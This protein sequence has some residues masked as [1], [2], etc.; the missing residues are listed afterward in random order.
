MHKFQCLKL[1]ETNGDSTLT[2][3]NEPD[4]VATTDFSTKY[5]KNKRFGK[6]PIEK[7]SILVFSWTDDC[8]R[9]ISVE[10]IKSIKPLSA[11]LRNVRDGE[12]KQSW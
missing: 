3:R 4:I 10:N 11:T 8:F 6:F 7:K 1:L 5:I 12:E 9:N 2:L